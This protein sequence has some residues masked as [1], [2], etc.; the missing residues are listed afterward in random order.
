MKEKLIKA[1]AEKMCYSFGHLNKWMTTQSN[2][3]VKLTR[4]KFGC[5]LAHFINRQQ[6]LLDRFSFI[7]P[8]ICKIGI[9]TSKPNRKSGDGT[10]NDGNGTDGSTTDGSQFLDDII[11]KPK[12][13]EWKG[14]Q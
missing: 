4:T 6:S 8:F 1:K 9:K 2:Y 5:T 7:K 10:D 3:F 13:T 11:F 12:K 14:T